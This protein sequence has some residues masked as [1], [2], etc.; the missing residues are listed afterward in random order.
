MSEPVP[1]S[2]VAW[3]GL[4][5]W[6]LI[7]GTI[8]GGTV[9]GIMLYFVY[10]YRYRQDKPEPT[11]EPPPARTRVREALILAAISAILLFG[12]LGASTNLTNQIQYPPANALPIR[13]TAFQWNFKFEYQNNVTTLGEVRVPGGEPVVFN[14]TSSDV[15]HN[16]GLP[17]FKLKIDAMPG[18]YNT[19]WVTAPSVTGNST[20]QYQIRCNE[21]CG[22]GHSFMMATMIV[23]DPNA[24]TQWLT[25][26]AT[27]QT[28]G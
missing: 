3:W 24:F 21:L 26:A 13:V 28:G 17:A 27:N 4:F 9:I 14:V 22:Q 18:M 12:L 5:Q 6:F 25:Q 20:L 1:Q 8:A 10:K 16:F 19:L 23:M 2:A 11:Y 7:V 15:F